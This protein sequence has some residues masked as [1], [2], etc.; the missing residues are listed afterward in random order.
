[1]GTVGTMGR[2]FGILTHQPVEL[3]VGCVWAC[4]GRV[5]YYYYNLRSIDIY[6]HYT[7]YSAV[8]LYTVHTAAARA[9]ESISQIP[10]PSCPPRPCLLTSS[11]NLLLKQSTS[12]EN[13]GRV[14]A[15]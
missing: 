15:E 8:H 13:Q 1:M 7:T 14:G 12:W 5:L 11:I 10:C 4:P 6:I 2:V 3:C 9:R